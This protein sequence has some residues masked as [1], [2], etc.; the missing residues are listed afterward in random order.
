MRPPFFQFKQFRVYHDRSTMKV[1][2]D[3]VLIG[4]WAGQD[5]DSNLPIRIL[6]IGC[7][8]GLISLMLAQRFA[9]S[10]IDAID[11]DADSVEQ[12]NENFQSSPWG[13]R[14]H[15][16]QCAIQQFESCNVYDLIVS[17]PPFFV[18]SLNAPKQNRNLARHQQ[19]LSCNDLL[20]HSS[21]LLAKGGCLDFIAPADQLHDYQ[22]TAKQYGLHLCRQTSVASKPSHPAIRVMMSFLKD[23]IIERECILTTLCIESDTSPRSNDYKRLTADFYL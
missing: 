11:I 22:Q 23:D 1:G 10:T 14:I 9:H 18:N 19:S 13:D 21:R 16:Y 3:G 2:T 15:A 8:S 17:N 6:D 7:G 12:A 4:A 20:L 5:T